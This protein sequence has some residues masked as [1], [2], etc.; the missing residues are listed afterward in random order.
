MHRNLLKHRQYCCGLV[1]PVGDA[2]VSWQDGKRLLFM[3]EMS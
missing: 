3:S 1:C 2:N